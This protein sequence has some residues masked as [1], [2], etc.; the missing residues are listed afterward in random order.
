MNIRISDLPYEGIEISDTIPLQALNARLQE[1][2]ETDII[3]TTPP[4][5]EIMAYRRTEGA[6][7]QGTV[8]TKY[9]QPC[10]RCVEEIERDLQVEA[11][12]ILKPKPIGLKTKTKDS[13]YV[14]DIGIIYYEGDHLEIESVIQESLIISL[15]IY[16]SAPLDKSGKCTICGKQSSNQKS[17]PVGKA[18]LGELMKKAGLN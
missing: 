7:I 4:K 8:S 6:E 2:R 11:N 1:G 16:W 18:S 15:S 17:E 12:Y 9:R 13:D 5:V 14:G 10:G 3:F